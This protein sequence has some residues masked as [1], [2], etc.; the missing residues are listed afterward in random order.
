MPWRSWLAALFVVLAFAG[1]ALGVT[2]QAGA[3]STPYQQSESR[4]TG[5]MH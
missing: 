4:D 5:G 2:S 3:P 1:C